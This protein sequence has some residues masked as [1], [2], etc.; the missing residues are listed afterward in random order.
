M[1]FLTFCSIIGR[2]PSYQDSI[3]ES[4]NESEEETDNSPSG[5]AE[6]ELG[7]KT[8]EPVKIAPSNEKKSPAKTGQKIA[9]R[10]E[11]GARVGKPDEV[12]EMRGYST[13]S[14][15]RGQKVVQV[16]QQVS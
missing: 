13:L 9:K 11:R 1:L 5:G 16:S 10:N 7:N 15:S 3:P 12:S 8:K 4:L 2:N 6:T 14:R